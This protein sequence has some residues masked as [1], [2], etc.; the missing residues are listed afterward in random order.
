MAR[1]LLGTDVGTRGTKTY[2]FRE[3]GRLVADAIRFYDLSAPELGFRE[4]NA[5]DWWKAVVETT[6]E[7]LE[8]VAD[9]ENVA[10]I[11]LSA[12]GGTLV[13]VDAEFR[14]L[15]PA[16][17][18]NDTRCAEEFREFETAGGS[19]EYVYHTTGW[20]MRA[21][22]PVLQIRWIR[23]HEPEVFKRTAM[24]LTVPD[25]ISW[26][27]TG[28]A[29]CDQASAGIDHFYDIREMSYDPFLMAFAGVRREQLP[30]VIPTGTVIGPLKKEAAR[31]LGLTEKTLFVSGVHDQYAVA[32]GAG[33][34]SD[35]DILI[36]SGTAWVVTCISGRPFFESGLPQS[37]AACR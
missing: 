29:A 19:D 32:A 31:E 6:R 27:M 21:S 25:F 20:H 37:R 14:P 24:F 3:D 5:N 22:L 35:G 28:I 23:K 33:A 10:A 17:V 8:A 4:Q 1:Y 7:V 12:Q 18:W 9:P 2:L 13:P 30:D 26:K 16:I 11:S 15:R 34:N 36:S